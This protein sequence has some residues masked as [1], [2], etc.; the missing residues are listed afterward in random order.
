MGVHWLSAGQRLDVS[1]RGERHAYRPR[2]AADRRDRRPRAGIPQ[3]A[4][5]LAATRRLRLTRM[6]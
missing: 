3:R 2:H 5:L 6:Q 4:G 1:N